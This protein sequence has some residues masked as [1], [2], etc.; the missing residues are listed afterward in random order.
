MFN[1]IWVLYFQKV[2][3]VDKSHPIM[4]PERANCK[5]SPCF[6]HSRKRP[7]FTFL[8][9]CKRPVSIFPHDSQMTQWWL[10]CLPAPMKPFFSLFLK[11]HLNNQPSPYCS[12]TKSSCAFCLSYFT[13]NQ[14]DKFFN[15][16]RIQSLSVS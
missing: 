9:G 11:M 13:N 15:S 14:I 12:S 6:A 2:V 4:I 8:Q 3:I 5:R 7:A 1:F 10:P 16:K